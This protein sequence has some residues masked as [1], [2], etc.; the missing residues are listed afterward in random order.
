MSEVVEKTRK[1][2]AATEFP[3]AYAPFLPVL[4]RLSHPMRTALKGHLASLE[5]LFNAV[6]SRDRHLLGDFEG[7]GGLTHRGEL[8]RI[9]QSE[10]LLR[11]EAPMEFLRRLAEH[12]TLYMETERSD[13]SEKLI[14]RLIIAAGPELMGHGRIVALAGLIFLARVAHMR[15]TELHW[16]FLPNDRVHWHREVSVGSVKKFLKFVAFANPDEADIEAANDIWAQVFKDKNSADM[17]FQDWIIGAEGRDDTVDHPDILATT[18]NAL[19]LSMDPP[20][21]GEARTGVLDLKRRRA[22]VKRVRLEFPPD[23]TCVSAL[24]RPFDPIRAD[25][26]GKINQ[27]GTTIP[28]EKGWEPLYFSSN[29]TGR[30][31]VRFEHFPRGLLFFDRSYLAGREFVHARSQARR[32]ARGKRS[33][34]V[35][36]QTYREPIFIP[37][38]EDA[39]LAGVHFSKSKSQINVLLQRGKGDNERLVF[40]HWIEGANMQPPRIKKVTSAH[41]FAKQRPHAIP[42]LLTD[43]LVYGYTTSGQPFTFKWSH[44]LN[45]PS[46]NILYKEKRI[47]KSDGYFHVTLFEPRT[48]VQH[49]GPAG[50][51]GSFNQ[52]GM[53]LGIGLKKSKWNFPIEPGA[54]FER[55]RGAAFCPGG[56]AMSFHPGQWK[57]YSG[58]LNIDE[59]SELDFELPRYER[60]IAINDDHGSPRLT[61]YSDPLHGGDGRFQ[62][63]W[64]HGSTDKPTEVRTLY[65]FGSSSQEIRGLR[66]LPDNQFAGVALDKNGDPK[67]LVVLSRQNSQYKKEVITFDEILTDAIEIDAEKMF[68]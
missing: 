37:L 5:A 26:S 29:G 24:N 44:A 31:I 12:E 41:L 49:E 66:Q 9:L 39:Q 11:T 54:N 34:Q 8:S 68:G 36:D 46:I 65:K 13:P 23:V 1:E 17:I 14:F 43:K 10:L 55:L 45:E 28:T 67:S 33:F 16:C 59:M 48:Q 62:H 56:T 51:I 2:E 58:G 63:R 38:P 22:S 27:L 4:D 61:V 19:A 7:V 57:F 47:L 64:Y 20:G 42:F 25:L 35:N 21:T 32:D 53:Q 52:P 50:V 3:S 30:F 18:S 15:K 6:Q 40:N 60:V